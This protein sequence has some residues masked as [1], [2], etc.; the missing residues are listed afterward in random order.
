MT[1]RHALATALC[2]LATFSTAAA[3]EPAHPTLLVLISVDQLVP[4]L[5]DRVAP[6]LDGGIK[7][8]SAEGRVYTH[9][10]LGY[11][12]SATGPGHAT[13]GTGAYP[14]TSG[15]I[16]NEWIDRETRKPVYCVGDADAKPVEGEGGAVSPRN[17]LVDGLGDWL[18]QAR[19]GTKV[20]SVGG[21]DR[22]AI[23]LAGKHPDEVFWYDGA[24]GHMVSSTYYFPT[25]LPAWAKEW[26]AADFTGHHT[27]DAWT[28]L[29]PES[30]Y[31]AD[32]PD[33]FHAEA[34]GGAARTFPHAFDP[35]LK[36]KQQMTSPYWDTLLLDFA[37]RAVREEKLGKR[38][39]TDLLT[40]ALSATDYIGHTYGP[41][42]HEA[43]DNLLRLDRSLGEFLATLEK[44]VG[45]ENLIVA[46]SADH[47]VMPNPEFTAEIRHGAARRIKYGEAIKPGVAALDLKLRADFKADAALFWMDDWGSGGFLDAAAAAKAGASLP[48]IERRLREGLM[49]IDGVVDVF[50]R[51]ELESAKAP[52][53][54]YLDKFRRSDQPARSEDFSVLYC[55]SCLV[56]T[57]MLTAEHGSPYGY[58]THVPII[59]WGATVA[60][61]RDA[62]AV[63]TVDVAPTLARAAGVAPGKTAE[64]SALPG[65]FSAN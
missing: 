12:M 20:I 13:L 30:A 65:A 41:D 55:E 37:S 51:D 61:G 5:L 7:R 17:L 36:A 32:G 42:S 26:N 18:K 49:A 31:A 64:G 11:A 27:P 8:I 63:H 40:I 58:D 25:R 2:L 38:G 53:R 44:E 9:A 50:F 3:K 19:R 23:L 48:E 21:K 6:Q 14:A 52:D 15:I 57:S 47:A 33:D 29:L 35:K 54:P 43:H 62:S 34:N 56:A 45:R 10:D 4:D 1:R 39:G 46:L 22:S 59:L 60:A 16:G 28:K 24:T